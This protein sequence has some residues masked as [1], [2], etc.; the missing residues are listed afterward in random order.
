[1]S[2]NSSNKDVGPKTK[3]LYG[4]NENKGMTIWME[5][6]KNIIFS[7]YTDFLLKVLIPILG[8]IWP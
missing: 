6:V 7:F 1:M 5:K 2:Y 4:N 3:N 8:F